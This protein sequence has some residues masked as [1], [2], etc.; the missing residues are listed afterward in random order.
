[1]EQP[2]LIEDPTYNIDNDVIHVDDIVLGPGEKSL[3]SPPDH[4]V[5][6]IATYG[7]LEPVIVDQANVLIEGRRR[8]ASCKKLGLEEVP[9]RRLTSSDGGNI[10]AA[11]ASRIALTSHA[12]RGENVLTEFMAIERLRLSGYS[13]PQIMA[14]TGLNVNTFRKRLQLANLRQELLDY[15]ADGRMAV[16][17]AEAAAKLDSET[18]DRLIE[19]AKNEERITGPMVKAVKERRSEEVIQALEIPGLDSLPTLS[20]IEHETMIV[21][22]DYMSHLYSAIVNGE[23]LR[24][25]EMVVAMFP[26][27]EDALPESPE[28]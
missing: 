26:D 25:A 3:P 23:L 22:R 17:T 2:R 24:A 21:R 13:E 16:T 8:V 11:I 10:D 15:F 19:L 5:A 27:V 1:M 6:S 9:C 20:D 4:L 28:E 14:V 12:T 18:Q 7:V